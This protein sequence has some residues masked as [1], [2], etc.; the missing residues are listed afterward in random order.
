RQSGLACSPNLSS[1]PL[2]GIDS[3]SQA[4]KQ[5]KMGNSLGGKKTT[6]VMKIDGETFKLRTAMTAEKIF[7]SWCR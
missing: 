5:S 1:C 2:Y 7:I 4:R 6:K 3:A